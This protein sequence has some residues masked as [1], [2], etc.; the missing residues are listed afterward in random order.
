[1]LALLSLAGAL[2]FDLPMANSY[3]SFHLPAVEYAKINS[4]DS[5]TAL[6]VANH[7][8]SLGALQITGIPN[9]REARQAALENLA[10]CLL[11]SPSSEVSESR[12]GDGRKHLSVSAQSVGGG[13]MQAMTGECADSSTLLRQI[14]ESVSF[15]LAALLDQTIRTEKPLLL[16]FR[17]FGSLTELGDH[18][19]YLHAFYRS[20]NSSVSLEEKYSSSLALNTDSGLFIAMTAAFT[21]PAASSGTGLHIQLPSQEIAQAV[22]DPHSLIVLVGQGAQDWLEPV[23]GAPMRALPYAVLGT[24]DVSTHSCYGKRFLPPAAAR[25]SARFVANL[26]S[27]D[28]YSRASQPAAA[29]TT[30][31]PPSLVTD[32]GLGSAVNPT[33]H[34]LLGIFKNSLCNDGN[35]ILCGQQCFPLTAFS[36]GAEAECVDLD[37]SASA[38]GDAVCQSCQVQCPSPQGDEDIFCWG[39][40]VDMFMDGF[41]SIALQRRGSTACLSLFFSEWTLNSPAKFAWA[42]VG[43]LLLGVTIEV[44]SAVR[45]RIFSELP[46]SHSRNCLLVLLH[47]AQSCLG[48]FL[49]LAAMT[50]SA[51]LFLMVL[52]G[53]GVGHLF[54]NLQEPPQGTD[55]CCPQIS[56]GETELTDQQQ[57]QSQ[58][59]PPESKEYGT[60]RQLLLSS[61][62][63]ESDSQSAY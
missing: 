59:Q 63:H 18:R 36:C 53:I 11:H 56:G 60:Y 2:C 49:M 14:V 52:A 7:L 9:Y 39:R 21:C 61:S 15:S 19:E 28:Y 33:S 44:L 38:P 17:S 10:D 27:G 22:F 30:D 3:P 43:I 48:Y 34:R 54:F 32:I 42:C 35:G 13:D 1:M 16:P 55:P 8:I 5:R 31:L 12:L 6:E 37:T 24:H 26:S 58:Q 41:A 29:S 50:Y 45:R 40:G 62:E 20:P 4:L 51:E 23:L 25:L 57:P 46:L 47:S